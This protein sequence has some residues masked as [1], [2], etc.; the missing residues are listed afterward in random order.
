MTVAMLADTSTIRGR[1]ERAEELI[2]RLNDAAT[3]RVL[4]ATESALMSSLHGINSRQA[5]QCD[6]KMVAT[7]NEYYAIVRE[8]SDHLCAEIAR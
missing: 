8:I 3:R 2:H 7:R 5:I 6:E 1:L 4:L